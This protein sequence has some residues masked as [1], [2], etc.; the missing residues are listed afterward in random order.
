MAAYP[1]AAQL[2]TYGGGGPVSAGTLAGRLYNV[3]YAMARFDLA[4]LAATGLAVPF[5]WIDVEARPGAPTPPNWPT[6]SAAATANNRQ[7]LQG[8]RAGLR[9]AGLGTGWYSTRSAWQAITGSWQDGDPMWKAGDYTTTGYPGALSIC[10]T[11]S[12]NG[13]PIWMGQRVDG[14]Y[15]LDATCLAL[16]T[17]A[18]IF[19][20]IGGPSLT[21]FALSPDWGNAGTVSIRFSAAL[22]TYQHWSAQVLDACS[23]RVLRSWSGVAK[24][25]VRTTWDGRDATGALAPP[26]LYTLR[27]LSEG[28][29]R[30]GSAALVRTGATALAGC[31]LTRVFGADRYA[32]AVAA[33]RALFPQARTVVLA[34]GP[35]SALVDGLVS[36]P[37]ARALQAPLLLTATTALSPAVET[38]VRAHAVTSAYVVGAAASSAVRSRLAALGVSVHVVSGRDRFATSVAVSRALS[39]AGGGTD[40]TAFVGSGLEANWID[41]LAAGGP[42]A[43]R[44]KPVLLTGPTV[45]PDVVRAELVRLGVRTTYVLGST[46]AVSAA[47]AAQLPGAVRL[48]GPDRYATA[49]AIARTFATAGEVELVSGQQAHVVDVLPAGLAGRPVLLTDGTALTAAVRGWLPSSPLRSG[50]ILGGPTVV[51]ASATAALLAA[52]PG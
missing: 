13:G 45:L 26:G 20:G 14:S 5:V 51:R 18:T 37:L 8:I 17:F 9:A 30:S 33:G 27:Y 25:P 29:T 31:P 52:L 48:G 28:Q 16:P 6:G 15:D 47:V 10:G 24:G 7:V 39:A 46:S 49:L 2:S 35:D 36:A 23:G 4:S 34:P 41:S 22:G 42:A 21:G 19:G 12:L 40:R 44:A 1:T 43:G 11:A 50:R 3:G 32:T 38:D